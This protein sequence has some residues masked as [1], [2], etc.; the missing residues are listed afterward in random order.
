[1][2]IKEID[3][4]DRLNLFCFYAILR[5]F[6]R[7]KNLKASISEERLAKLTGLSIRTIQRYVDKLVEL[8]YIK[9]V[10]K[11]PI[12][13]GYYYN[14]Y[15]F[16]YLET[17][18]IVNPDLL[19]RTDISCSLKGLLI[20]LKLNCF[21]GTNVLEFESISSLANKLGVSRKN[22]KAQLTELESKKYLKLRGDW[23][24]LSQRFFP[25]YLKETEYKRAY[26][27]IYDYCILNN[28]IPPYKKYN[29]FAKDD[30]ELVSLL[31]SCRVYK[32]GDIVYKGVQALTQKLYDRCP[33][34]P[35]KINFEYLKSALTDTVKT[36]KE[37]NNNIIL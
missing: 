8:Q 17:Y 34:L 14:E 4:K 30:T 13:G 21:Y 35:N 31:E 29:K 28:C 1:M 18:G 12:E 23:L 19:Y 20:L 24:N 9:E 22:L 3:S 16:P 6:I 26:K 33:T 27:E 5:S 7:D 15:C 11:I 32:K 36:T 25:L 2:E 37:L 10:R